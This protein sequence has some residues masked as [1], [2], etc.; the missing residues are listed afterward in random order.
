MFL[1]VGVFARVC[2][3]RDLRGRLDSRVGVGRVSSVTPSA[4]SVIGEVELTLLASMARVT[5][6]VSS[7]TVTF[8]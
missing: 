1:L 6:L 8:E 3:A 2:P 4:V 7:L 5:R